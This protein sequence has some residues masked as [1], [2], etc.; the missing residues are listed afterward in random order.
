MLSVGGWKD[1]WGEISE[2]KRQPPS[3]KDTLFKK[4]KAC[5]MNRHT[6]ICPCVTLCIM[7][8]FWICLLCPPHARTLPAAW[9]SAPLRRATEKTAHRAT[10]VEGGGGINPYT[11]CPMSSQI[12][13][14][15]PLFPSPLFPS[16]QILIGRGGG[17][18][19]P[20][21]S[22][23]GLHYVMSA[24]CVTVCVGMDLPYAVDVCLCMYLKCIG[25]YC[26]GLCIKE[27]RCDPVDLILQRETPR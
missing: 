24:G 22:E 6:E 23:G 19:I 1:E 20:Q 18:Q 3:C 11:S 14:V 25:L 16:R 15:N 4:R 7:L 10:D 12:R 8:H 17:R 2:L 5:W 9:P 13:G 27:R 21:A 26:M